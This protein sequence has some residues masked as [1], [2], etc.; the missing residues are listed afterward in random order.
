MSKYGVIS[1][2]YFP[3]FGLNTERYVRVQSECGKIRTRSY[4]VFGHF[5]CSDRFSVT[6]WTLYNFSLQF[7][8]KH[9]F[10][11]YDAF[12][13][14]SNFMFQ[15]Q[16]FP[17]IQKPVSWFHCIST[18]FYMDF[19]S[20]DFEHAMRISLPLIL[21]FWTCFHPFQR[22]VSD[23]AKLTCWSYFVKILTT[24]TR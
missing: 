10:Y 13:P 18:S 17:V 6:L 20:I 15:V 8:S 22:S 11:Q 9:I 7:L 12:H 3:A 23:P 19:F 16:S 21:L 24:K 1:G 4:S 14:A 2:P 5:S